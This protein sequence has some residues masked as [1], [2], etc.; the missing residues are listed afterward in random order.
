MMMIIITRAVAGPSL[1]PVQ[2]G[3]SVS[4]PMPSLAGDMACMGR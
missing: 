4:T 1:E 2:N 3:A